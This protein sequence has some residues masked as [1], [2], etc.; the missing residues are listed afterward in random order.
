MIGAVR[1]VVTVLPLALACMLLAASP[2]FGTAGLAEWEIRTPGGNLISHID[3]L[4]ARHGTCLR[5][6][7]D[8]AGLVSERPEDVYVSHLEWWT[9]YPDHVVG[10]AHRG[11]FIFQERTRAVDGYP[12]ERALTDALR[13]R[14]SAR[15]PPGSSRP[16]TAGRKSGDR[17]SGSSAAGS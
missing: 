5:K 7:D 10:K 14:A 11:Y 9:Y 2:C 1:G 15:R 13:R 16:R 4:I 8:T 12:T 17:S 3:P 6:A